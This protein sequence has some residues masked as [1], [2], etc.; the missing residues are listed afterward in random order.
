MSKNKSNFNP[1]LNT[2]KSTFAK[3]KFYYK[4]NYLNLELPFSGMLF[5]IC[6]YFNF[7]K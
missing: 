1:I 6:L 5:V 3:N 7:A 4:E 2:Y